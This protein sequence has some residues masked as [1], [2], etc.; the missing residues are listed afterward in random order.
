MSR[1]V[2]EERD[3]VIVPI[4]H[5]PYNP[6]PH[7]VPIAPLTAVYPYPDGKHVLLVTENGE[8]IFHEPGGRLNPQ[9]EEA[10][11]AFLKKETK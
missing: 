10:Y 8:K 1:I 3:G 5:E 9:A 4:D 6:T 7:H 2:N 11:Q